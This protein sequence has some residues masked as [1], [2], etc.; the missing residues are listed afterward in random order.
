MSST[1]APFQ[2]AGAIPRFNIVRMGAVPREAAQPGANQGLPLPLPP[3]PPSDEP[4]GLDVAPDPSCEGG[5]LAPYT[6]EEDHKAAEEHAP[7]SVAAENGEALGDVL[8]DPYPIDA[9]GDGV[10]D[11]QELEQAVVRHVLEHIFG[12]AMHIQDMSFLTLLHGILHFFN[13]VHDV[14]GVA[15]PAIGTLPRRVL[16]E[17]VLHR[18]ISVCSQDL[19]RYHAFVHDIMVAMDDVNHLSS[20]VFVFM[21]IAQDAALPV[22]RHKPRRMTGEEKRKFVMA[23]VT[24]ILPYVGM[25]DRETVFAQQMIEDTIETIVR[26]KHGELVVRRSQVVCCLRA[27]LSCL[28]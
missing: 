8:S 18:G 14:Q 25:G 26:A 17:R 9:N 28:M 5:P 1:A 24:A 2:P 16:L 7:P 10:V 23:C 13:T 19:Q 21:R 15:L 3:P 27:F 12:A 4:F 20:L 22:P 11:E 6:G